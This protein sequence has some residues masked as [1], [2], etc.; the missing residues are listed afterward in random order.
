MREPEESEGFLEINGERIAYTF[1]RS[2][3]IR[4]SYIRFR[5]E[6]LVLVAP[7]RVQMN[8]LVEKHSGWILKHYNQIRN[9]ARIFG[10]NSLYVAGKRYI[11]LFRRVSGRGGVELTKDCVIVS[12]G[13]IERANRMAEAWLRGM[14]Q[15]YAIAKTGEK[16][17]LIGERVRSV[18]VRRSRKW[19]LC[20]SS[21]TI[22][23]NPYIAAL[24]ESIQE[25]IISHEVAHLKEMN[26]SRDFWRVVGSMQPDYKTV[27][28]QLQAYD[29]RYREVFAE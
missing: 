11:A 29:N 21:G 19:G 27:R 1:V 10:R 26:H 2:P 23:Y 24:P 5:E 25:Y 20:T 16:A 28:K 9:S 18:G 12:A 4:N 17:E 14:S 15:E 8:R 3:G 7:N 22:T 6:K 13:S